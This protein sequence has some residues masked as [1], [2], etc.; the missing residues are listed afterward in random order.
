V[1][2]EPVELLGRGCVVLCEGGTL[3]GGVAEEPGEGGVAVPAG[4]G[5]EA[6][7]TGTDG[8]LGEDPV[9]L[10]PDGAVCCAGTLIGGVAEDPAEEPVA[11]GCVALWDGGTSWGGV[12]EEPGEG[13]TAVPAGA[14]MDGVL[15]EDPVEA[16]AGG[17]PRTIAA[18]SWITHLRGSASRWAQ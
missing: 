1:D 4:G 17:A 11:G 5:C 8:V 3:V 15:V 10:E 13:G 7:E 14:G 6:D 16:D 9:E 2:D 12:A 18:P